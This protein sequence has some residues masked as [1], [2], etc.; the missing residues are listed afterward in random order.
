MLSRWITMPTVIDLTEQELSELKAYTKEP[1]ATAAVRLA[2]TEYLRLARRME[3]KASSGRVSMEDNWRAL[4][5]S[6]LKDGNGRSET[7][8]D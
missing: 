7:G 1:D 6:E 8:A 5:A 3:L 4:E 2:M